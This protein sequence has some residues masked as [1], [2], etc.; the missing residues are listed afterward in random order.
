MMI[1]TDSLTELRDSMKAAHQVWL[2]ED[3]KLPQGAQD[4][5]LFGPEV[6]EQFNKVFDAEHAYNEAVFKF[7]A[8]ADALIE[9][10][11]SNKTH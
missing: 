10:A 3:A 6:Q 4:P 2:A 11:H 7:A 9:E 5:D 8:A 1:E